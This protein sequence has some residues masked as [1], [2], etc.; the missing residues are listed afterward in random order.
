MVNRRSGLPTKRLNVIRKTKRGNIS[1]YQQS[2][3]VNIFEKT[4]KSKSDNVNKS[5]N[6]VDDFMISI[7][8]KT[9]SDK[10]QKLEH[11]VND[12]TPVDGSIG[13]NSVNKI[14]SKTKNNKDVSV[15]KNVYFDKVFQEGF[16]N[17]ENL[18]QH[19]GLLQDTSKIINNIPKNEFSYK[20]ISNSIIF[21]KNN[22]DKKASMSMI[23]SFQDK[24]LLSHVVNNYNKKESYDKDD[25]LND[26]YTEYINPLLQL[27]LFHIDKIT[28]PLKSVVSSIYGLSND[29]TY[30]NNTPI[31]N[32]KEKILWSKWIDINNSNIKNN[33]DIKLYNSILMKIDPLIA[34]SLY[35]SK[36]EIEL[37]IYQSII[38]NFTITKPEHNLTLIKKI[39]L[40]N[41]TNFNIIESEFVKNENNDVYIWLVL[42]LQDVLYNEFILLNNNYL[43]NFIEKYFDDIFYVLNNNNSILS[44][45]DLRNKINIMKEKY[46]NINN[47][48]FSIVNL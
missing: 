10:L 13:L 23:N 43:K 17:K 22:I 35:K 48:V 8:Q 3:H 2:Y 26:F 44:Q 11:Y 5:S 31:L 33:H 39:E 1:M 19:K 30:I 46:N 21:N 25:F 16:F 34:S 40:Q 7:T 12:L 24:N 41:K 18:N 37:P 20:E 45:S 27:E 9:K 4:K 32:D 28:D 6:K 36:K 47:D 29:L 15:L 42:K 38:S 14:L